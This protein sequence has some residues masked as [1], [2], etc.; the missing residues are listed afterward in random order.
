ME[1]VIMSP[2]PHIHTTNTTRRIMLDV[3]IS[4]LPACVASVL[5]FGLK[6]LWILLAC[7]LSAVLGE[8]LLNIC[9]RQ[10]PTVS[11]LSA[12]VTGILLALN[13]S[14]NVPLWQ[15]VIG[16]LFAVIVVK[17]LFGGLGH[18]FANPA[19]TGRV[20]LLLA[21][22]QV[23]GGALPLG[24]DATS[25]ATPLELLAK[26]STEGLPSL[27]NMLLGLR[28]GAIGEGCIV[29][30]VL[31]GL[32]LIIRRQISWQVPVIFIGTVFVLSLIAEGDLTRAVYQILAGGLFLGA[33]FMATDYVTSPIT[34]K[35]K[36]LFALGCGLITFLI[37][38]FFSYPEGVSF[39]I[40]CMNILTP[41]LERLTRNKPLGGG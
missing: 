5:I 40:L 2:A 31:G 8:L 30:L 4:L 22:S 28:G 3:V 12:L 32:Y 9:L 6:A 15:C 23:A 16:S 19:I 7:S 14:A 10:K 27:M 20:F 39:S 24:V 13:L 17:G 1:N 38:R 21:F 26:G 36:M 41:F 25:S 11:D 34:L 35:G 18:N 37:R 33:I 29:A